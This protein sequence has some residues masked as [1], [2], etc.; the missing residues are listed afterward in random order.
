METTSHQDILIRSRITI[1]DLL[2][3]RGYNTKPY[4]KMIG[5]ELVKLMH[6]PEALRMEVQSKADPTK[7][8]IVNYDFKNIKQS[9]GTGDFVKRMIG[10]RGD[11]PESD[12][13][14]VD[15]KTTEV[16]VIFMTK[17]DDSSDDME[18]FNKGAY[19]AWAKHT[20]K[21]QFF[22]IV[23]LVNNP[24]HHI[25]QPKFE[26][27]PQDQH[28]ALLKELCCTSKTQ[29]PIIRFHDDMAGR[30]LGLV[31]LDIVKITQPSPTAGEYVKYRVCAP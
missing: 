5:S 30:C 2:E 11:R 29:L 21:I 28:E 6:S 3:A 19:E 22:P 12:L 14:N 17:K 18:S 24:L 8:A 7:K 9:V 15:P 1:L 26:I 31:P 16:I 20:L 4:R 10:D 25:V 23:R 13:Y 27:V